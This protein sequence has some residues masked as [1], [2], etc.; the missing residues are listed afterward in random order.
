MRNSLSRL[1]Q[2]EADRICCV[3]A[4]PLS[5]NQGGGGWKWTK[6]IWLALSHGQERLYIALVVM[7][8]Y[9]SV[10]NVENTSRKEKGYIVM[11]RERIFVLLVENR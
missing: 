11:N 6:R 5:R 7:R 3:T 1:L 9:S 4:Y 8:I 10:M 2:T